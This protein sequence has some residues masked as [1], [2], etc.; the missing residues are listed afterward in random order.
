[1]SYAT[2]TA[3]SSRKTVCYVMK[4]YVVDNEPKSKAATE[5]LES[6]CHVYLKDRCQI[7]VID[8][9]KDFRAALADKVFVTPSL[10]LVEPPPR[11]MV[12]GSLSDKSK[13]MTALRIGTQS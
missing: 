10:L 8:V 5:N 12:V 11:A 6:I 2:N 4:L 1:M 9:V 3:E 13:V 7:E